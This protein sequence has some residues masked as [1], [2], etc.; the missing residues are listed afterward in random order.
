[1]LHQATT[2]GRGINILQLCAKMKLIARA[3]PVGVMGVHWV[4]VPKIGANPNF[5]HGVFIGWWLRHWLMR[6][7]K[8]T[9]NNKCSKCS[10]S[11]RWLN[12]NN[13][14][15][16]CIKSH[17]SFPNIF[18]TPAV[19]T[20][21]GREHEGTGPP[22]LRTWLIESSMFHPSLL[23]AL[24]LWRSCPQIPLVQLRGEGMKWTVSGNYA[25]C[26]INIRSPPFFNAYDLLLISVK[27]SDNLLSTGKCEIISVLVC[28][29][30]LPQCSCDSYY[31]F[32]N[33]FFHWFIICPGP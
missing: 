6:C 16:K 21:Q 9:A 30:W 20:S 27:F 2:E 7:I 13:M 33:N 25:E 18:Q 26:N 32:Q 14:P 11:R 28:N 3:Q 10:T 22:S 31:N 5:L 29:K 17:T 1:M 8:V 4:Q 24:G 12:L 23:R 15:P 19:P